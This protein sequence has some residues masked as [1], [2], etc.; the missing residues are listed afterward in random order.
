MMLRNLPI[1]RKLMAAMLI[2]AGVVLLLT[3][4]AF[5]TY[6]LVIFRKEMV[7]NVS[8]LAEVIAAN[9]TASLAFM[10]E[11]DAKETLLALKAERQIVAA[12]LY[13]KDGKLFV[14]Y[15]SGEPT[16][17]FPSIPQK[18]GY[19][20][21]KR[22]LLIFQP[23]IQANKRQG[24]LF[25]KTDLTV[26]YQRFDSYL[27]IVILV[28]AL[29]FLVAFILSNSLQKAI[30]RP[31]LALADTARTVCEKKDYSVRAIKHGRDELGLLT[32]GFNQMLDQIR[33]INLELE[34]RVRERTAE[35]EAANKEL[36]S[37]SYSVSHDLRAPLRHVQGYVEMLTKATTGQ[38]SEKAQRHLKIIKDASQEMGHLIDD[39]L[40]FSRMG[41]AELEQKKVSLDRLVQETIAGLEM[42][43]Q[44]RNIVWKTEPLPP[45]I[46]DPSMLKQVFANLL[47]NAVKYTRPRARAEIETGAAGQENGRVILFVRDN[48]VGFDTQYAQKLFG[49]FQRMHRAEEFEGTGIGLANVHR[50]I[51]RHGGRVWA[52]STL[53]KGATFYFTLKPHP[54]I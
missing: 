11:Q 41:R 30:S 2:T 16:N 26:M 54:Q 42:A 18:D 39:L 1:K 24:S 51:A 48:G 50:I 25:L 3:S 47:D 44:G 6:E 5:I 15:P 19:R 33:Q 32:D 35:L 53:D 38:L 21:E 45:V 27:G 17:T 40:T 13:D 52:E 43:T 12:C 29:S 7:R 46:G 34:Q 37:F 31:I 36:E 10:N 28:L 9:S 8:T 20:F 4:T 22:Y 14:T 49:V 23:V